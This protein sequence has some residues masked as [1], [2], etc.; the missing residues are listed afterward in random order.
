MHTRGKFLKIKITHATLEEKSVQT[1]DLKVRD[2]EAQTQ[3]TDTD[4][5]VKWG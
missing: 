3:V 2:S 4:V 1:E 5:T